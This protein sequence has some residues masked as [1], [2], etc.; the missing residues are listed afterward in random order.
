MPETLT[1][2]PPTGRAAN[3]LRKRQD[4]IDTAIRI[5]LNGGLEALTMQ[6]LAREMGA[7]VGTAYTYFASKSALVAE[8]Q[9]LAV[10]RLRA[11]YDQAAPAW[12][13]KMGRLD[14]KGK[15]EAGLS[16]LVEFSVQAPSQLRDDQFLQQLLLTDGGRSIMAEDQATVLE[17]ARGWTDLIAELVGDA[18][19]AGVLSKGDAAD[20]SRKFAA[21]LSG[22]GLYHNLPPGSVEDVDGLTRALMVDLLVGWGG[23]RKRLTRSA[24]KAA[25]AAEGSKLKAPKLG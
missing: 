21:A 6:A 14:S 19:S 12:Q 8:L 16:L 1:Q 3:R 23:D 5:V 13:Q 11:A 10:G 2:A 9:V 20:R 4:Y 15:A 24:A 25:K 22:A 7:A 17:A 18:V